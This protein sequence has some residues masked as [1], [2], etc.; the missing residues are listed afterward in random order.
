MKNR[1]VV[2]MF[3][4]VCSCKPRDDSTSKAKQTPT[5]PADI[6]SGKITK[7]ACAEISPQIK[8][9]CAL[10]LTKDDGE[11]LRL[12]S[13]DSAHLPEEQR[14]ALTNRP[15]IVYNDLIAPIE[16]GKVAMSLEEK[17]GK[18]P[19]LNFV[20]DLPWLCYNALATAEKCG[21]SYPLDY[22]AS[23]EDL[24]KTREVILTEFDF[25][26]WIFEPAQYSHLLESFPQLKVE[27][28][29]ALQF[30]TS[31]FYG[32][33]NPPLRSRNVTEIE[34]WRPVI[35]TMTSGLRKLEKYS[36]EAVRGATLVEAKIDP[37][38]DAFNDAEP[39]QEL[40]FMSTSYVQTGTFADRPIQFRIRS[41]SSAKVDV[42]SELP[43]EK[44]ALFA[45]GTWFHVSGFANGEGGD[46]TY[47]V[48]LV[49]L[50]VL[51]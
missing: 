33:I 20:G 12:V 32:Q 45:P 51:Q 13:D 7:V 47:V 27:E 18:G 4:L 36:G 17:L 48:D 24:A 49:E 39:I 44:E 9:V 5:G 42:L 37:Y 40:G 2:A 6:V 11:V 21:L 19:F 46:D 22:V 8:D 30:Y 35:S 16:E 14:K 3:L 10:D 41:Y 31:T 25:S 26:P 34:K 50:V 38:L 28:I 23:A 1:I 29:V 43:E 15:L